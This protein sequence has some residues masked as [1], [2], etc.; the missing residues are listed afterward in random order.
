MIDKNSI[1]NYFLNL[2]LNEKKC[3]MTIPHLN[4]QEKLH[5]SRKKFYARV[6]Q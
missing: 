2:P 6:V 3:S 1:F 4:V 5:F